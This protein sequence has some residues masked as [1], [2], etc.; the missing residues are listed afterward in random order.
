MHWKTGLLGEK[1]EKSVYWLKCN[2]MMHISSVIG[3]KKYME[4]YMGGIFGKFESELH[5][6]KKGDASF[7]FYLISIKFN[8]SW[9]QKYVWFKGGFATC[10]HLKSS[11]TA[12]STL[13]SI[14]FWNFTIFFFQSKKFFYYRNKWKLS[15]IWDS[16]R[17]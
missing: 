5:A 1:L 6:A 8:S 2:R 16:S 12:I 11:N 4:S 3:E 17:C 9:F 10:R 7:S 13:L 14:L 15:S